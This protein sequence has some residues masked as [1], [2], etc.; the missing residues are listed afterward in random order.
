MQ[1]EPDGL[2]FSE[3]VPVEIALDPAAGYT[4]GQEFTFASYG[5]DGTYDVIGSGH[6]EAGVQNKLDYKDH[7]P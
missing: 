4:A 1:L 7:T 5:A 2:E 3:P 6:A